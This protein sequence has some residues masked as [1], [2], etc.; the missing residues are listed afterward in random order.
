M[1]TTLH[2]A[3]AGIIGDIPT[4]GSPFTGR[5]LTPVK[6]GDIFEHPA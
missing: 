1:T 3:P 6:C 2:N 5:L 4:N